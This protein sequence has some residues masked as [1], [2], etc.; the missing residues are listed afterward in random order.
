MKMTSQV[1]FK[2]NTKVKKRAMKRALEEGIP[3]A[4]VLKSATK[5][6][7]E[8]RLSMELVEEEEVRPEKLVLWE[9]QS[10][11]LDQGKGKNFKSMK[12][13]RQYIRNL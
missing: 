8:G 13:L 5:A 3:F 10:R 7:A 1:V 2:V 12:E 11:L 6:F 9:R 4:S